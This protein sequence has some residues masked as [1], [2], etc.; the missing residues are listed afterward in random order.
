MDADNKQWRVT[1]EKELYDRI[2]QLCTDYFKNKSLQ[3]T[4][5]NENE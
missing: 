2:I 5:Q 4:Q 1:E 3:E